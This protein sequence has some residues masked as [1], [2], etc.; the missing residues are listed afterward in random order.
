MKVSNCKNCNNL[1]SPNG[2]L[3]KYCS[4]FCADTFE[5]KFIY[6]K[7][8]KC[9]IC[10]EFFPTARGRKV[11]S[12]KCKQENIKLIKNKHY[13]EKVQPKLKRKPKLTEEQRLENR[14]KYDT[15]YNNL[16]STK[17][18]GKLRRSL[19]KNKQKVRESGKKYREKN[20]FIAKNNHLL[21]N[22][23]INLQTYEEMLDKQNNKCY[24]CNKEETSAHTNGKIRQLAVDHCHTTGKV[25]KLLCFSCNSTLGRV[26]ESIELLTSMINYIKEHNE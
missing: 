18:R 17:E 10:D 16:E 15:K 12:E 22:F 6:K 26:N 24:I 5:K 9:K 23:N 8:S 14:R 11:C 19:E 2:K 1:F 21:R 13:I 4:F 20:S 25:R 3:K 7:T